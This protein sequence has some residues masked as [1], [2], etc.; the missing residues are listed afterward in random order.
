MRATALAIILC[1]TVVPAAADEVTETIQAALEAYEAG[2]I[3]TAKEELDFAAQLLSQL[4]AEGLSEFLPEPF[5]GW[6]REEVDTQA[7]GA[8]LFGGGQMAAALYAS[9]EG[10][11]EIR[12]MADSPM[13]TSMAAVL[14]NPALMGAMGTVKRVNRQRV[15]ITPDGALQALIDGRVLVQIEGAAPAEQKLAYFETLDIEGLKAF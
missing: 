10:D 1:L 14:G 9:D 6:T 8:S 2:D 15:V 11:L 4:K 5:E 3:A 7:A 12:L 13:V